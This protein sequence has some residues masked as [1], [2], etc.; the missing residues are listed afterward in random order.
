MRCPESARAAHLTKL[1][2]I[3]ILSIS[4]LI[5]V[6]LYL[7]EMKADLILHPVRMRIVLTMVGRTDAMTVQDMA[8]LLP[9][10]PPATLYRH[11]K[12]LQQGGILVAAD[13]RPV[14]GAVEISYRLPVANAQLTMEDFA[15]TTNEDHARYF[16]TFLMGLLRN[17]ET[18]LTH[19]ARVG[20]QDFVRDGVGYRQVPLHLS[21]EEFEAFR[22]ELQSVF[23]KFIGNQPSPERRR[24]LFSSIVMPDEEA[25]RGRDARE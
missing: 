5:K 23:L 14:R 3:H 18:Y 22:T 8:G 15:A 13:E 24:R 16:L 10:I 19:H 6:G 11:V 20:V 4:I 9:D 21:D 2:Y 7:R 17:F 25:G 1:F 12:K